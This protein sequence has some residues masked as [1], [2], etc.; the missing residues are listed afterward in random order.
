MCEAAGLTVTRL[1][2]IKIGPISVNGIAPGTWRK[3]RDDEVAW[4]RRMA[5]LK[6]EKNA[7]EIE[8]YM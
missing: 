5:K 3:L 6:P 7:A 4:L 2:R 8:E 1:R